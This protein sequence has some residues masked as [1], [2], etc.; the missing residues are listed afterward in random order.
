MHRYAKPGQRKPARVL[1]WQFVDSLRLLSCSLLR[2]S[3]LSSRLLR[4]GLLGRGLLRR[5]LAAGGL[6]LLAGAVH[7]HADAPRAA[8]GLDHHH[9]RAAVL[10]HLTGGLELAAR[11]Q[12]IA[13][14]AVVVVRATDEALATLLALMRDQVAM[15]ARLRSEERRVGKE[16]RL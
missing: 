2:G 13:H 1:N 11:G 4:G 10:A 6:L 16:C 7:V 14:T 15:T 9:G 5:R 12:R 8:R 3:L